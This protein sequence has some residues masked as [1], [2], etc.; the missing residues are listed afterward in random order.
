[1]RFFSCKYSEFKF[2]LKKKTETFLSHD[3]ERQVRNIGTKIWILKF[4]RLLHRVFS[5]V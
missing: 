4:K 2:M 3:N 5:L 1:M